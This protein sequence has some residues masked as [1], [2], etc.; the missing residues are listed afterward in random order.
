MIRTILTMLIAMPL[1]AASC[2]SIAPGCEPVMGIP[3]WVDVLCT[4]GKETEDLVRL[5]CTAKD[6][7]QFEL[8]VPKGG[9]YSA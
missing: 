5:Y 7:T 8:F 1:I 6:G 9:N 2:A 3:Q 4:A